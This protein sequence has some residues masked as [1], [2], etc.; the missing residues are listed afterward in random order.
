MCE[1][2]DEKEQVVFA[3][4]TASA[5]L[6]CFVYDLPVFLQHLYILDGY[7]DDAPAKYEFYLA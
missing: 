2:R 1:T 6:G 4:Y 7:V 3:V 5:P